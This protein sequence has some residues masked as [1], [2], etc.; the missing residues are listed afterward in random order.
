MKHTKNEYCET[1]KR[2][3]QI[4][5]VITQQKANLRELGLGEGQ[6]EKA[7]QPSTCFRDQLRDEVDAHGKRD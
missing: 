2:L 6:I 4:E 5:N 7:I 1:Q 3:E